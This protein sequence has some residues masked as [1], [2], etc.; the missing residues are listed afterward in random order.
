MARVIGDGGLTYYIQDV[1]VLPACQRQGLGT[2]LMDAVMAY[3]CANAHPGSVIG[4]MAA[5]GKE[6]FYQKYGF[7][8]R[9]TERLG[10]G[11]TIFWQ[12][13]VRQEG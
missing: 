5:H 11:M 2:R 4:L 13:K 9:P 1:I 10:C 3:L 12:Q 8:A 7:V 6:P